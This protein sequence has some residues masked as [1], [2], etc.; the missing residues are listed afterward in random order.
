VLVGG[1][2]FTSLLGA[3]LLIVTGRTVLIEQLVAERTA[4]LSRANTTLAHEI[5]ERQRVEEALREGEERFHGAFDNA[6]I[7]LA[8]V[9]PDG[10]W[11]QVNRS[12]CD[13]LGYTEHELL[14]TTFQA[15][16]H[17]DD[18]AAD[19][20][21]VRRMLADEIHVYQMEKRYFHKCGHLVW[22]LLS[23]SLVRDVHGQP[24]YFISQIQDITQRKQVEEELQQTAV[25]LT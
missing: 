1:L 17:P 8:L 7:G 6:P 14:A 12:L 23:V 4:D 10:R 16:T 9:A 24:S 22:I 11:L 19:L 15:I 3:F 21:S 20:D 25:E 5:A 18:L 2:S 13:I